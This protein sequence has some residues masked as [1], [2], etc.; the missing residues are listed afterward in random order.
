MTATITLVLLVG[1]EAGILAG[2]T[3]SLLLFLWLTSRPHVAIVG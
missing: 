1:V 2:T 3:R